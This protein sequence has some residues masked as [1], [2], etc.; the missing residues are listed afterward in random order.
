MPAN[1]K[2]KYQTL[3]IFSLP[4]KTL[5]IRIRPILHFIILLGLINFCHSQTQPLT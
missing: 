2:Y 1:I 3:F 4:I 5:K